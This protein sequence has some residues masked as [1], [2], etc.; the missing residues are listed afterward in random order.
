MNKLNDKLDSVVRTVLEEYKW[1]RSIFTECSNTNA[2]LY[3]KLDTFTSHIIAVTKDLK[4]LFSG[5]TS[6]VTKT[7]L[8]LHN[9]SEA[10]AKAVVHL[11][12]ADEKQTNVILQQMKFIDTYSGIYFVNPTPSLNNSFEVYRDGSSNFGFGGNWTLFQRRFDGSVDFNRSWAEYRDGFGDLDGEHWL[13]LEKLKRLLD[14]ERHELLVVLEDFD[15]VIAHA[16]YDKFMIGNEAEGF[17]LKSL[18]KYSGSAGDTQ[19]CVPNKIKT[20]VWDI[21]TC[22]DGNL[23]PIEVRVDPN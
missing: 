3:D 22:Q 5:N 7:Q 15:G 4:A 8:Q 23:L 21:S 10:L 19:S 13:G 18:G 2:K 1:H 6:Y 14:T 9:I 11:S 16:R 20:T 17:K 12:E